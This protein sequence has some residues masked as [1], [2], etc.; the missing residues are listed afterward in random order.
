MEVKYKL[1]S[2]FALPIVLC[3]VYYVLSI[4]DFSATYVTGTS[5]SISSQRAS[6]LSGQS[7]SQQLRQ[8]TNNLIFHLDSEQFVKTYADCIIDE[9]GCSIQ[10]LHIFKSGGTFMESKMR[11]ILGLK[12]ESSWNITERF[13]KNPAHYCSARFSS[14]QVSPPVFAEIIKKCQ[15]INSM[16][17]NSSKASMKEKKIITMVTY[18]EPIVL[19]MSNIHQICNK[20]LHLRTENERAACRRC[21]YEEDAKFFSGFAKF[22]NQQLQ[23]IR[24][25]ANDTTW[26]QADSLTEEDNINS[27][28]L[29]LMDNL[30]LNKFLNKL[31]LALPVKYSNGFKDTKRT[32]ANLEKTENCN[33]HMP[34]KMMKEVE[35][36]CEDY[37]HLS[38]GSFL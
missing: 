26:R 2:F 34:S 33:F 21:N 25:L 1:A 38:F 37:R 32:D 28:Q 3:A 8:G 27:T 36:A 20:N 24:Q 14:Y 7:K 18:R 15:E 30:D 29:L 22:I 17:S 35:P 4:S 5:K 31:Q 9:D 10:Y 23:G 6:L 16:S 19:T 12:Y 13:Y 11:S